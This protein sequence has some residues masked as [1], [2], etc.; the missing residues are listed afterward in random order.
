MPSKNDMTGKNVQVLICGAGPSGLFLALVLTRLGVKVK[1]VERH[2]G[3][4]QQSRALVV[5]ARSLE[6][7]DELGLA[8]AVVDL[9]IEVRRGHFLVNGKEKAAF[10]FQDL[11]KGLSKY[12]FLLALPQDI[13]EKFL[14]AELRK[15]GVEV[16]WGTALTSFDNH[17][18]QVSCALTHSTGEVER[19]DVAY[20]AGCDGGS[21][22]VR[23]KLGIAFAGD[24]YAGLFYVADTEADHA[25]PGLALGFAHDEFYL[26][27]PVR[28]TGMVRIIGLVPPAQAAQ[29]DLSFADVAG[30]VAEAMHL[31]IR[32]VNWFSTY[33]VHH[34]V[35]DHFQKGRCFLVGDAGHVHSPVGAQ[36]MNT[37][38]VDGMNLGWKLASV[39][40]GKLKP[41]FL[42]TYDQ[43]RRAFANQLVKT[44]DTAFSRVIDTRWLMKQLRESIAP[45]LLS[46][47]LRIGA[48]RRFMFLTVSQTRVSYRQSAL[49]AGQAGGL[50][51]GDRLAYL[52]SLD[53]HMSLR[54]LDWQVHVYGAASPEFV[55][56]CSTAG[57]V[58]QIYAWNEDCA[59]KGFLKDAA[60]LVRPDG[61][62][63]L[64][65]PRPRGAELR[66]YL[67]KV[68]VA[69]R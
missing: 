38:L 19:L 39:L 62:V 9:G 64:A 50:Q 52:A 10:A 63:G 33:H 53:N 46:M 56:A 18:D 1:I 66:A 21:S 3:P 34:R 65:L 54:L 43:E 5:H 42:A 68:G 44:T 30:H 14:V 60:Y 4:A 12:P 57:V 58:L 41:E 23:E 40:S 35:A 67:L 27:L 49:S 55:A 11:G 31:T 25:E 20:L 22:V 47:A 51:G 45:P 15:L 59:A 24:S 26:T 6:F 32:K 36:G 29:P 69:A 8:E 37:G 17:P 28:Q 48:F 61:H 7:Y 2:S 13:H 16:N